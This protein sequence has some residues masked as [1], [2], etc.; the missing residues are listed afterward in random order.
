MKDR[1]EFQKKVI[2]DRVKVTAKIEQQEWDNIIEY[3]NAAVQK[4]KEKLVHS[5]PYFV[6]CFIQVVQCFTHSVS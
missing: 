6:Q 2:T 4:K 3:S 5:F 1:V